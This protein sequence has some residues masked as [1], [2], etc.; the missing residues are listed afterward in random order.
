[1]FEVGDILGVVNGRRGERYRVECILNDGRLVLRT[2]RPGNWNNFTTE[3]DDHLELDKV[4]ERN[5]KINKIQK[6]YENERK[7]KRI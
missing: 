2:T 4:Y 7:Y 1:M 3:N 5:K 6:R